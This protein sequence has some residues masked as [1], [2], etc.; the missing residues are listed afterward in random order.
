MFSHKT[1]QL[2]LEGTYEVYNTLPKFSKQSIV[3]ILAT[4]L[5]SRPNAII[6]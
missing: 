5:V 2:S 1:Y 3:S 6:V 4:R